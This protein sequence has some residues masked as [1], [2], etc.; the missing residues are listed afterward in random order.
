MFVAV[1]TVPP[2]VRG[3]GIARFGVLSMAWILIGY[4]SLFDLGIGR[5]LTK[6]VADKLGAGDFRDIPALAW[7]GLV[8]LL[9]VGLLVGA[10]TA[11]LSPWLTHR[12]LKVPPEL[13]AET[14]YSFYLLTIAIP[15][16]TFTSGWRGILEAMQQF[17]VLNLIRVPMSIFSFAGPLLVL[18][19][20]H[21]LVPV[22]GVLVV[23]RLVGCLAHQI[24]CLRALPTMRTLIVKR[25]LLLPLLRMGGWMTV[26]N[27]LGPLIFYVDRFLIGTLLSLGAV[28]YYTAPFDMV[29][30]LVFIPT[31]IAGV[32]FPAFAISMA[33]DPSRTAMLLD[34][35]VKYT[36][37]IIFPIVLVIVGLAPE[38]LRVW[39]GA[40]FAESSGRVLRW[41]AVGILLNSVAVIPFSLLQGIGR[42][43]IAGKVLLLDLALYST[44]AWVLIQKFGIEGA[45]IAW[46][47]RA[48]LEVIVFC[49]LSYH[50]LHR[51]LRYFE[52]LVFSASI[53]LAGLYIST[54]SGVLFRTV[55]LICGV[56]A[57]FFF[58]WSWVLASEEKAWIAGFLYRRVS[59]P[60]VIKSALT[61][62][63]GT[64]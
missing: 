62:Q 34:R 3:L 22:V 45:A 18:P 38:I 56:L 4:F 46:A 40:A 17:R 47:V 27:V 25:V 37:S 30:R 21:S 20:S 39:L 64:T 29:N 49:G 14:L 58:A 35:G 41:L 42:A 15:L 23:G 24:A 52:V 6:L 53:V 10:V 26:S 5:A 9:L 54:L 32:L 48:A 36:F 55:F 57:F 44:G 12:V 16:V 33:Q 7:T 43:D 61:D 59:A 19:F 8:M 28:A 50:F 31:A 63:S 51:Q 13:Q 1:L 2:L 60:P 11:A